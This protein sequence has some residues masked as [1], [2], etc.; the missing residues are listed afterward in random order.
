MVGK[1]ADIPLQPRSEGGPN[2]NPTSNRPL[3]TTSSGPGDIAPSSSQI[4]EQAS[5]PLRRLVR[6]HDMQMLDPAEDD[7][8]GHPQDRRS[9]GRQLPLSREAL[10]AIVEEVLEILENSDEEGCEDE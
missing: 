9:F 1:G 4:N 5:Q 7:D 10:L 2:E 8:N 3:R 6:L